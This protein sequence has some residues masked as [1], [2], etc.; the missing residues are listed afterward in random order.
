MIIQNSP[1]A[2][3]LATFDNKI[4]AEIACALLS[5]ASIC[6][7]EPEAVKDGR[8]RVRVRSLQPKLAERAE[9]ILRRARARDT[10]ITIDEQRTAAG[11]RGFRTH[12][13][14]CHDSDM[15]PTFIQADMP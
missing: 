3:V 6:A 2:A 10:M 15:A 13:F 7:D 14:V 11:S 4:S 12:D 1:A 8:W 5:D 9:V